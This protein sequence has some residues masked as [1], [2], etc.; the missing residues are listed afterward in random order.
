MSSRHSV[1]T[2]LRYWTLRSYRTYIQIIDKPGSGAPIQTEKPS[3]LKTEPYPK[4]T[5]RWNAI[6]HIHIFRIWWYHKNIVY[7]HMETMTTNRYLSD[8]ILKYKFLN[9][10][11]IILW[12]SSLK[13]VI[14]MISLNQ[15]GIEPL[16][17]T[18]MA[19]FTEAYVLHMASMRY[20]Y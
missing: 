18:M 10:I 3:L 19:C 9:E 12:F 16:S 1:Q 8:D 20:I 13:C 7:Q 15:S 14:K 5:L 11:F 17:E 4:L 6:Y 2:S